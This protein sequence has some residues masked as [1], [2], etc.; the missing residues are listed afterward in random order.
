MV[1]APAAL[2]P[3]F[4]NRYDAVPAMIVSLALL[5]LLVGRE[6][7]AF[8]LLGIGAA[9]K[10]YP[11]VLLPIALVRLLRTR[12]RAALVP[13]AAAFCGAVVAFFA[14]FAALAPGG[15]GFSFYTQAIR[16]LQI[17]SLGASL[18][19]A[20]D[21]LGLYRTHWIAGKPSS[22]DLG[23]LLPDVVGT[24]SSLVA[25]AAV[26]AVAWAY[27][28][29]PESDA[30]LVTAFAA[31][32]TAF[33]VFGKVLSPQYLVWLVPLVPVAA[34]CWGRATTAAFVVAMGLTPI[35]Y[36]LGDE[37][38][39]NVNGIVWVLL[40]RNLLLVG[41]LVALVARL[42]ER[43]PRAAAAAG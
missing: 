18:L 20:A 16:H 31:A 35:E 13:A 19:L 1:V 30:R 36:F 22:T 28:R 26:L 21:K 4:L 8:L 40:L 14:F 3:L 37:G 2:G 15:V 9:V 23:G 25:V 43:E 5:A 39:R 6:R 34:A 7:A 27:L 38:L 24:V 11:V 29:G 41:I 12:G 33:V 32:V 10:V 17:E 42:W